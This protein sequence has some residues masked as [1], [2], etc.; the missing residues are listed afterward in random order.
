MVEIVEPLGVIEVDDEMRASAPHSVPHHEMVRTLFANR[1][2]CV[3]RK[4]LLS[5]GTWGPQAFSQLK[6]GVLAHAV[7]PNQRS[8]PRPASRLNEYTKAAGPI[9]RKADRSER[10]PQIS[11]MSC[12]IKKILEKSP[13]V[14]GE[15]QGCGFPS[16]PALTC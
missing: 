16:T 3:D 13:R 9:H 8:K 2:R 7:L 5:G 12:G 10:Q 4:I 11:T 1:R 14:D 15:K 6:E